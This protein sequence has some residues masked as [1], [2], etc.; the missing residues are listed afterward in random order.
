[1]APPARPL[2]EAI[3]LPRRPERKPDGYALGA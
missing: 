1:M 3:S 2:A